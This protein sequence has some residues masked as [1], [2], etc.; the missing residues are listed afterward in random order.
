VLYRLWLQHGD[1][2]LW[3]SYSTLL[4]DEFDRGQAS[5]EGVVRSRQY[6]HLARRVGG[7]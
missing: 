1:R 4:V 3:N 2:V 5:G 6:R 7:A